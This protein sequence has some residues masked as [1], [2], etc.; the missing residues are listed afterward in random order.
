MCKAMEYMALNKPVVAF[1]LKETRVTCGDV[2]LYVSENSA[3]AFTE[4]ILEL[5]DS[6]ELRRD[7]G[8]IGR[9]RIERFFSWTQSVPNLLDAYKHALQ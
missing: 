5:A 6:P 4:K 3:V 9:Q 7:M 2:A 1:N 8:E